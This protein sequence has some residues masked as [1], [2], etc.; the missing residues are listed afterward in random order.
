MAFDAK[1]QV[2][3]SEIA[4]RTMT[5]SWSESGTGSPTVSVRLPSRKDP[6]ATN[7]Q[8]DAEAIAKATE[9]VK[10]LAAKL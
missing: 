1:P 10:A 8:E 6:N 5:V 3:I 7:A 4:G 2:K 9:L